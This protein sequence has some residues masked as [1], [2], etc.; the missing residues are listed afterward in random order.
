MGCKNCKEKKESIYK[1]TDKTDRKYY[2][3][4]F[5]WSAFAI[6]GLIDFIGLFL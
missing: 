5:I 6:Y 4:I 3:F 2:V 1:M